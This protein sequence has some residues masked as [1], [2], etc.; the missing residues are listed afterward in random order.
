MGVNVDSNKNQNISKDVLEK[1]R[2]SFLKKVA[3]SAPTLVAL[4]YLSHPTS[5]LAES[6]PVGTP[7][8]DNSFDNLPP[9]N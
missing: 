9:C 6:G 3:Y 5:A 1:E 8:S 4:G 2:R 7:C